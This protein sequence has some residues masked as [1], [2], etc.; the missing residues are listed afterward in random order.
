M[1][2]EGALF[3][4]TTPEWRAGRAGQYGGVVGASNRI[5]EQL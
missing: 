5:T 2:T 1:T 4:A 3:R